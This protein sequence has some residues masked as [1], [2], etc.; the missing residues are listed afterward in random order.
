M[1]DGALMSDDA[2]IS[3]GELTSDG[4]LMSNG[5][6]MSA[7][8]MVNPRFLVSE[9][10]HHLRISNSLHLLYVSPLVFLIPKTFKFFGFQIFRL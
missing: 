6:L 9:N 1:S 7:P 4:A 5:V 8:C 3:D 10:L 2:L